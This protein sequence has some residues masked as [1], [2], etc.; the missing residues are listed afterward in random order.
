MKKKFTALLILMF[1]VIVGCVEEKSTD[2]DKL[3]NVYISL[4][5][6]E[7]SL[8]YS[9]NSLK[10]V[11]DSVFKKYKLS[12]K[13]YLSQL[14]SFRN[15]KEKWVMF[16]DIVNAKLDSMLAVEDSLIKRSEK[17][18]VN[19]KKFLTESEKSANAK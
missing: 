5:F 10:S 6:A 15:D 19:P 8:S 2:M 9:P 18:K 14:E 13:E 17:L 1:F 3:S 4:L 7:D 16:F 12:R 11:R